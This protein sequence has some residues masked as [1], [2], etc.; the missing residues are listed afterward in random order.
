MQSREM[1]S[2]L[3]GDLATKGMIATYDRWLKHGKDEDMVAKTFGQDRHGDVV[4][5]Y[6]N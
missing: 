2:N 5:E 1:E 4:E 3:T 6:R